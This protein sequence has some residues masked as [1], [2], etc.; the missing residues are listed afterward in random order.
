MNW[1]LWIMEFMVIIFYL[2]SPPGPEATQYDY[3]NN[4]VI[5][6]SDLLNYLSTQSLTDENLNTTVYI[7]SK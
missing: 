1:P 7:D 2:G 5:D 3:N 6:M 4:G